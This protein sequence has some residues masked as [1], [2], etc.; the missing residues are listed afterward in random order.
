[1]LMSTSS[2]TLSNLTTR[3]QKAGT[4][5]DLSLGGI[6]GGIYGGLGYPTK[7]F[8][9]IDVFIVL[10]SPEHPALPTVP[11]NHNSEPV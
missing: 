4:Q 9:D 1:M 2:T 8:P 5:A 3:L 10:S 7:T 6:Y 11:F